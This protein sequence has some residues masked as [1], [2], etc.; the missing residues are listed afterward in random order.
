MSKLKQPNIELL[1]W[2]INL[3]NPSTYDF[4]LLNTC[5]KQCQN[6][7]ERELLFK[8]SSTRVPDPDSC[9]LTMSIMCILLIKNGVQVMGYK[10]RHIYLSDNIIVETDTANSFISIYKGALMNNVPNYYQLCD[11]YKITGSFMKEYEKIYAHRDEFSLNGYNNELLEEFIIFAGLTHSIG[12][13]IIGPKGFNAADSKSK[14]SF[15]KN[16]WS[17]FDR[18]D[19]F[20]ERVSLGETYS[21]W[22]KWYSENCFSTYNDFFY[23]NIEQHCENNKVDL[24]KSTLID[25][26]Y[27]DLTERLRVINKVII[28]RGNKMVKDLISYKEIKDLRD[29]NF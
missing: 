17:K 26:G 9:E 16:N 28:D 20:L 23:S 1:R 5:L 3:D 4:K 19:L 14:S 2:F 25:L 18:I 11:K 15:N 29:E 8:R 10:G 6:P 13:F 21:E 7:L 24:K 27:Q 12:N 22:E